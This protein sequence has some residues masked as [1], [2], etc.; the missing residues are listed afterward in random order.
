[1]SDEA[2]F[3]Y[4][5]ERLDLFHHMYN[6][7]HLNERAVEMAIVHRWLDS[8]SPRA[9]DGLEIGNVT[10]HYG[11]RRHI[12][13]DLNEPASWYQELTGQ[14]VVSADVLYLNPDASFPWVLSISTIEHTEDPML[15]VDVLHGLVAPGGDLLVTFPTGV[16]D[17]LDDL[18]RWCDQTFDRCCTIARAENDHG[19]WEQT[20]TVEIR[21]YGPWANSVF[22]G[23]WTAPE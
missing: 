11:A 5:G 14:P 3:E 13:Y 8:P 19:G 18:A 20:P 7:T 21:P 12:V 9:D 1:M 6:L 17:E 4:H 15:A 2:W 22:V 10:G 23:E 16:R